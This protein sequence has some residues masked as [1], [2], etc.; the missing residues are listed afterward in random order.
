[1]AKVAARI[2]VLIVL[3][4]LMCS[5]MIDA[6][7]R[8]VHSTEEVD[9][10]PQGQISNNDDWIMEDG[11]TFTSD[12][13][14]YTESMVEDNRI[15]IEHSRPD[16]FQT[17]T[18]WS[19]SSPTD[20]TLATGTA[21]QQYSTTKGPVIEVTDFDTS[22]NEQYEIVGVSIIMSFHIPGALQQDQV[23]I[24][25]NYG[26]NYEE[27][28]TYV[29]TQSAIDYMNGSMWQKNITQLSSW[30]W[31]DLT[32]IIFTLDY[33]SLGGNDDT[34][35]DV[36]AVGIAVVV[37][38]PWYGTEWASVESTS[39][40][41][42][43]P[44]IDVSLQDGEFTN[45]QVSECGIKPVNDGVSGTWLSP[46]ITSQPGQTL[47]RIHYIHSAVDN[48]DLAVEVSYS[49]D[50]QIFSE[51]YSVQSNNLVD[52]NYLKIKVSTSNTCLEA[53]SLDYNDPTLSL[54][55]KI[56][57]SIDGLATDYSRWKVFINNQEVTFQSIEQLGN[58]TINL[59]IGQYM[60][61]GVNDLSVK[62]QA[63]F[64]WD[65]NG[66]SS[67]T[68]LEISSMS[69][70]G[71]F[72]VQWDEDPVCQ[73]IAPQYFAEDGP[74]LL[75]PLINACQDD[76]TSNENLTVS[77][78]VAD[79]SLISASLVQEDIKLVLLPETFGVTTVTVVVSDE[80]ANSWVETFLVYVEEVD[81]LP[82]LNEFPSIIPVESGKSTTIAFSY[83]DI[84]STGLTV[85]TDKTWAV[86]DLSSSTITVTPPSLSSSM[87]VI[88]T[89]CDQSSCVNR[90]MLLEV[91]TLAEL[92]VEQIVITPENIREG[93][94][95]EVRVYVRNSGQEEASSISVRCQSGN[96]L[97][98]IQSISILMPGQL[99]VV[100]C[101]WLVFES[102]SKTV[103]VE[104]DRANE[105]SEGDENNNIQS[106][107]VD[108][109]DSNSDTTSSSDS[110]KATTVWIA[111]FIGL[112]VII[113]L[114]TV[115][116]P[117]KIKKLD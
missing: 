25:M 89:L 76:R 60:N 72:D 22:S 4:V 40:N 15:T 45:L 55:G 34:Q 84:D 14:L 67:T 61:S 56:F 3:I 5:S 13:A 44:I 101:D 90:T 37:K 110:I 112:A 108:V 31:D 105:V 43:M 23:R 1:M 63:W 39:K 7:A 82:N 30:T 117:G 29:N 47:G 70:S 35:L 114:F 24:T 68:L 106:V 86:V 94:L 113:G 6:A 28:A 59:S 96:N 104:L 69:I 81:D 19:S 27:L 77:L 26:G 85:T 66:Q 42:V 16:N 8:S 2:P 88:V 99:G 115:L 32:D 38:Y 64:N 57:G 58:F 9:I 102:G 109:L 91:L 50:G 92:S 71:G 73:S 51:Y 107:S 46:I 21:D 80:A 97:I 17:L 53:I 12:N 18:M 79:D 36:D 48:S 65:S 41:F 78:S 49:S 20:S 98:A 75:I 74:G 95:V 52:S 83:F 111:T 87:P 100:T 103:S 11:I 54:T 33:V 10:F 62:I 116:A 93:D